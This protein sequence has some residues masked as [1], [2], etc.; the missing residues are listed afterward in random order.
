MTIYKF[1]FHH[2]RHFYAQY[3]YDKTRDLY[4]VAG[5]LGHN[6]ITTTQIYT[7]VTNRELREIH[8]AFHGKRRG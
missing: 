5:L 8:K 3:I 6:Q 1:R 4:A 2:L 7:H